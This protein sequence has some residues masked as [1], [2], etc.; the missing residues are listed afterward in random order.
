MAVAKYDVVFRVGWL[1]IS[2]LLQ[3]TNSILGRILS[4]LAKFEVIW[5]TAPI[6]SVFVWELLWGNK[7]SYSISYCVFACAPENKYYAD[8]ATT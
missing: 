7:V 3:T 2:F 4:T 6:P 1:K 8:I 5:M